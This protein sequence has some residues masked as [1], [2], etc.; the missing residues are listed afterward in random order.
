MEGKEMPAILFVCTANI[1]RSPMASAIFYRILKESGA[2]KEWR[3]ESAGTWALE[4]AAISS[5]SETVMQERSVDLS[6]HRAR[7]VSHE[8][9]KSFD[10]VL[11]MERGHKEALRAE[12][13]DLASKIYLLSEMAG[14]SHDIRDPIGGPVEAYRECAQELTRLLIQGYERITEL[15]MHGANAP[16]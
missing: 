8:L 7:N 15:V 12:F 4:G 9:L 2:G 11:T 5:G 10:L 14:Y 16:K 13:P 6:R 1:C 3:V